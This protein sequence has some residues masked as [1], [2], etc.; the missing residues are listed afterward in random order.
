MKKL[1]TALAICVV[2]T[3]AFADVVSD[4]IVGYRTISAA[5]QFA[6]YGQTFITVGDT[7]G[8]WKLGNMKASGMD[9]YS[10]AIQFLD[11][12]D[13]S[14]ILM[15]SYQDGHGW[16]AFG[17]EDGALL[18][19]TTFAIG[20]GFLCNFASPVEFTFSGEVV[21]DTVTLDLDGQFYPFIANPV[22]ADLKLGDITATGM[23]VYS[24]AIQVLDPNDL[25]VILMASFQTGHGWV[26]FGDEDGALL[27]DTDVPAGA[28][29]L[30]SLSG[31]DIEITFPN[32][33]L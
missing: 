3:A 26:A 19:D 14:V 6:S 25:S 2:A 16:V 30:C 11:P 33:M 4:N 22:P 23:D 31:A 5:G 29:L 28:G 17:D 18:D 20:T 7:N 1:M 8:E 9:V 32:P 15:A 21:Q 10:D 24:D 12:S 13:Q 27:D